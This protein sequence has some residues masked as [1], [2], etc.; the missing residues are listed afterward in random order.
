[1]R[2]FITT[3]KESILKALHLVW[4]IILVAFVFSTVAVMLIS[5]IFL[6]FGA[7]EA[8][9]FLIVSFSIVMAFSN[10]VENSCL[11]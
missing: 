7:V 5:F 3:S 8:L 2:D 11:K 4:Q 9:F 10:H 1:M 6:L